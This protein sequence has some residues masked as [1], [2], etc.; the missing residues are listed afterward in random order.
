MHIGFVGLVDPQSI[1]SYSGTPY[2]MGQAL[3]RHGCDIS[4]FLHLKEQAASPVYF[5]DKMTRLLTGKHIIPERDPRIASHYPTQINAAIEKHPAQAVLGTS[6]FYMATQ[7]CS[8]P[9]VFWGD[10]TV[11]GVL[12]SYPYY[13]RLTKRSIR[14]C[15][16]LEQAALNSSALAI[17]SNQW[18]ADVA[19]TNYA[20]DQRK[21]RVIPYGANLFNKLNAN[22]I[23]ECVRRRDE[24]DWELLFVG[25]DWERKGAQIAVDMTSVLRA[26]GVN[27]RLTLVGCSPPRTVS[28]PEY[29]TVIGKLDKTTPRGQTLLS[30]LY[31][32]SHLFVLPTRAE[33]AAVSLSEASAHGLPSLSTDVGGNSTLIK[34]GVN[35]HLLPLEAGAVDYAECALQLLSDSRKYSEMCWNSFER[36]Q[37]ELNWDVAVSKLI[38]EL[39]NVLELTDGQYACSRAS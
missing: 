39:N 5:R 23:A 16:D 7:N 29:V 21:V 13:K 24:R 20:F 36:F 10:T 17:F 6:S 37:A 22:D 1:H 8:V 3:I 35:G 15:H 32:Q 28:L 9:S 14:H 38:A 11:A 2:F 34:N 33:C 30:S 4:F 31:K 12:N 26:R 19:C 25:V 27:V 18:A